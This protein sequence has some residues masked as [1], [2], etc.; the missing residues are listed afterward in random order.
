[1]LHFNCTFFNVSPL[2]FR[3]LKS[4]QKLPILL[5]LLHCLCICAHYTAIA[6]AKVHNVH[7]FAEFAASAGFMV[8]DFSLQLSEPSKER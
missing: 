3:P 4:L 2:C 5:Y 8:S 7:G 6:K 1:M